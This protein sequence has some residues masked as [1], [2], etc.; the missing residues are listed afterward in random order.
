MGVVPGPMPGILSNDSESGVTI[1][2]PADP[3]TSILVLD[4]VGN[5]H[6]GLY[7][8]VAV[9]SDG[10]MI[11]SSQASLTY[12][13]ITLCLCISL[14]HSLLLLPGTSLG[15]SDVII[16]GPPTTISVTEGGAVSLPCVGSRGAPTFTLSGLTQTSGQYSL[17]FASITTSAAGTYTCQVGATAAT[18]T[19]N[20]SPVIS[21]Y[22][23]SEGTFVNE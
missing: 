11:T 9:F 14:D 13:G 12:S 17:D 4:S 22:L 16:L 20:V 15:V 7:S 21:E 19:V 23:M 18:V 2:Q 10:T 5:E 3:G 8:C 6:E 1:I